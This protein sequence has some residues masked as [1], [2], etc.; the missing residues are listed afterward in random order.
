MHRNTCCKERTNHDHRWKVYLWFSTSSGCLK[1]GA[2]F[3]FGQASVGAFNVSINPEVKLVSP[4]SSLSLFFFLYSICCQSHPHGTCLLTSSVTPVCC[5][6][7]KTS[8][9]S[10]VVV[11]D[12]N[13]ENQ[14]WQKKGKKTELSLLFFFFLLWMFAFCFSLRFAYCNLFH[15]SFKSHTFLSITCMLLCIYAI[16][17]IVTMMVCGFRPDFTIECNAKN[18]QNTEKN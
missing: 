4:T 15:V 11:S 14:S 9:S 16:V 1:S 2:F 10:K 13:I 5:H 7:V 3:C 17:T 6:D 8:F 12:C 18:R